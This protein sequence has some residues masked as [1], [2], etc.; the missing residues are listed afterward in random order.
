RGKYFGRVP[1]EVDVKLKVVDAYNSAGVM[2]DAIRG[3]KIAI[4]RGVTGQLDS[5]SAYCIKHPP[6]QKPNHEAKTSF[7]DFVEGK[8]ER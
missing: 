5:V 7:M 4:D 6:E 3:T 2:I 8:N 1:I